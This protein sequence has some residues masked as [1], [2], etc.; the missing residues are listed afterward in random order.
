[1]KDGE[2]GEFWYALHAYFDAHVLPS[3]F[4]SLPIREK[5]MIMA[6]TDIRIDEENKAN[7]K[8]KSR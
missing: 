5:A 6:F 1:M 3:T 2:N 4:S 7:K 8:N